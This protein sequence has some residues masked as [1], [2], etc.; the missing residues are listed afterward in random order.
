MH[1]TASSRRL[2]C[3]SAS[4]RRQCSPAS[5]CSLLSAL[6]RYA[7]HESSAPAASAG[8]NDSGSI[9]EWGSSGRRIPGMS[10][11]SC[12]LAILRGRA[13]DAE[14]VAFPP[15]STRIPPRR[16]RATRFA[17]GL[18]GC[19]AADSRTDLTEKG[20]AA[21]ATSVNARKSQVTPLTTPIEPSAGSAKPPKLAI[22]PASAEANACE[23]I[24]LV[25]MKALETSRSLSFACAI[26]KLPREA[27]AVPTPIP[28][29]PTDSAINANEP[30]ISPQPV[31][32]RPSASTAGPNIIDRS[33][34]SRPADPL[35]NAATIHVKDA[36]ALRYPP[37]IGEYPPIA[38]ATY[39]K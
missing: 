12:I 23:I 9:A 25:E 36:I 39:G 8:K 20:S 32:N 7:R 28:S 24:W 26:I 11:D 13:G 34:H 10:Q 3:S 33:A 14:E 29:K 38:T 15:A 5:D 35:P 19:R 16:G 37:I 18:A 1:S 6:L 21:A 22:I 2:W 31:R 30:I 17:S 27:Q 4:A